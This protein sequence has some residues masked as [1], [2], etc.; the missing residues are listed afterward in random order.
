MT[1]GG[2]PAKAQFRSGPG[3]SAAH[4]PTKALSRLPAD[5]SAKVVI[6]GASVG[7][8]RTAQALR[9]ESYDGRIV[10]VG[11]ESELPYDKPPLSKQFLSGQW[12]AER[13]AL[14]TEDAA[15][16]ARIELRLGTAAEHVALAERQVVLADGERIDYDVVILATGSQA[17]PSPWATESG[18]HVLRTIDDSRALADDL[19]NNGPVV[20]V[21]G[22]FIGAEVAATARSLGHEVT[23]VDPLEVPVGRVLGR[24]VGLL[25]ADLHHRNGVATHFGTGVEAVE[26]RAGDLTVRLTDGQSLPAATV[27]VGIGARPNDGWLASSGLLVD[28]GVVCNEYCQAVDAPEVYAVGDIARWMHLGHAES[29]RVEHWTN[30]VEQAACVAHNIAHPEDLRAYRPV[31]YVWSDQYDWKIQ[32]VGRAAR[33]TQHR[34]IGDLGRPSGPGAAKPRAVALYTDGSG[35]FTAAAIVNW[36]KAL[37]ASRKL[38]AAESSFDDAVEQL[39]QLAR[40]PS[41]P[42]RSHIKDPSAEL[43]ALRHEVAQACRVLAS[44]GLADGILGH[45]SLRIDDRRLLVRCRGPAERGLAFTGPADIHLVGLDGAAA[46]PGELEG[47]WAVPNE[48]PLHTE[49]LRTRRDV[50]AVVHA[51]PPS[52]VAA[53]LAG[54][55]IRPIVGAFDIPGT[56]LAHGGVPVYPRGVLIRDRRLAAEMVRAM[57]ERSIVILRAHGLTSTG[58]GVADAVLRALSINTIAELSLRIVSAGGVLANLPDED[59]AELPDLGSAFNTETAWRHELARLERSLSA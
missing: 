11:A 16:D 13:V 18:V 39:E 42:A 14:L 33:A 12:S 48:L 43:A 52:V 5:R 8:V 25:F 35:Q 6:V 28:D 59:L 55:A 7:G 1:E 4:T 57:G 51:H 58:S 34:L 15:E 31:E 30:A 40:T 2:T 17:R 56:R 44:R 49:V 50:V 23:I 46:G 38:I 3:R 10:V 26:G 45:V 20:V 27:V 54:I 19:A 29:C 24:E 21:G 9:R 36:P 47:G 22:G 53:D 37:I 41:Q 32:I